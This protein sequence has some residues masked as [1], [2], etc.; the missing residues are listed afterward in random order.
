MPARNI[1]VDPLFQKFSNARLNVKKYTVIYFLLMFCVS[2]SPSETVIA[3]QSSTQKTYPDLTIFTEYFP[4][5]NYEEDGQVK[6]IA[7]DL[8]HAIFKQMKLD[9]PATKVVQVP[10]SRGYSEAQTRPNVLLFSTVRTAE[11]EKMFKW[12]GPILDSDLVLIAY[13]GK[14]VRFEPTRKDKPQTYAVSHQDVFELELMRLGVSHDNIYHWNSLKT[15]P[16]LLA[17][18]RVDLWGFD[19]T[20]AF[21]A[22]RQLGLDPKNFNVSHQLMS[23]PYYYSFSLQTDDQ[24]IA[25]FQLALDALSQSGKRQRIIDQYLSGMD[26]E[27][28]TKK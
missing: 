24:F 16:L 9:I 22:F 14:E 27:F 12:A 26:T 15:A 3:E 18:N 4:P 28:P 23:T 21:F 5:F 25:D 6:G 2:T 11:R 1:N 13:K 10:W 17:R 7:V 19:R 20:A 8:L